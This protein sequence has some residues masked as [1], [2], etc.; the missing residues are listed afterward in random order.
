LEAELARL[1]RSRLSGTKLQARVAAARTLLASRRRE[2]V[3]A[4]R[5][6]R[7][8]ALEQRRVE[9]DST[10]DEDRAVALSWLEVDLWPDMCS[11]LGIRRDDD[12]RLDALEADADAIW[13][14]DD[15]LAA[16]EAWKAAHPRQN[17]A[18]HADG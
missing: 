3:A 11:I 1:M 2:R 14:A 6:A 8:A 18:S 17:R 10:S 16:W 7:E 9:Q 13:A 12:P 15:P 5:S 4:E